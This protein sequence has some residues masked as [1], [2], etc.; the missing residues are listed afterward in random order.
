MSMPIK[1]FECGTINASIWFETKGDKDKTI[2]A[3]VIRISKVSINDEEHIHLNIFN[4]ED[5]P[6]IALLA[7]EAY[8]HIKL[9]SIQSHE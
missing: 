4:A 5:L 8:K 2:D 9:K 7:N 3:Y 6:K 1:T